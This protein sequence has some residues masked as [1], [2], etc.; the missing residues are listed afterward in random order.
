MSLLTT[1]GPISFHGGTGDYINLSGHGVN[2]GHAEA[3]TGVGEISG[4]LKLR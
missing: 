3:G 4:V 1:V 2:I